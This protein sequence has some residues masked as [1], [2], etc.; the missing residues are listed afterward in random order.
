MA[1]F[2]LDD[3]SM[4]E[5]TAPFGIVVGLDLHEAGGHAFGEAAR[6]ARRIPGCQ[7]HLVHVFE[8]ELEDPLRAQLK[9]Q[10]RLYVNEKAAW[11]GGLPGVTVGVHLRS[12]GRASE[13]ARLADAVGAGM[14]VIGVSKGLQVKE[15]LFGSLGHELLLRARC[16]VFVAGPK[17][18]APSLA[19]QV[20][21]PCADCQR[22]R[23]ASKEVEWWCPRHS[24]HMDKA[25]VFSYRRELPLATHDYA[26]VPV[27]VEM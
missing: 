1:R 8:T 26:I 14:I 5:P 24:G 19:P 21:P 13:I 4:S 25:H 16:P 22:V 7:L 18:A 15:W 10:L 12:G 9:A 11:V 27:D 3:G 6:I 17:P 2:V 20:E 23:A